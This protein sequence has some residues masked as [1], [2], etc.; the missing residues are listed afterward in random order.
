MSD[1]PD[2]AAGGMPR[3]APA[4]L[5][6]AATEITNTSAVTNGALIALPGLADERARHARRVRLLLI[7]LRLIG[8][9]VLL[10]LAFMSA[11][12]LRYVLEFGR[13]VV[14]PESFRPLS[15]FTVYILAFTAMTLLSFQT[16][17]LYSL[18]R[19]ASWFDQ[20]RIIAGATLVGVAALTL[21]ALFFS[22]EV[23]SRLLFIYL[24][25]VTLGIFSVE[26]FA[27]K[28]L[29]VWLWRHGINIRRTIVVGSGMAGQRIMK[30]IVEHPELGYQMAG[31]VTDSADSPGSE[32]WRVPIRQKGALKRLGSLKDV[33]RIIEQ[34]NLNEVIV[35][36]PA[37]HHTQI[38][39]IID[40]CREYGVD[41][42][43]VP[44]LF[45]MRFNE[46]RID[47]LNDVPLIGVKDVALRGFNLFI[48]RVLDIVLAVV[49]L[50]LAGIPMLIIS[51]LIKATS[52]GPVLFRQERVGRGGELFVCYKFRTMY[53]DAEQ[54]KEELRA[55]NE[56]QGPM[57]KMRNDP[58][59]TSV[60]KV[61]RRTSLDE[62]PNLF[63]I[64]KGEMSWV[65]PRP[66]TPDEAAQ[67]NDWHRKRLDVTPGL[68]GLWQ[69]SGRSDLT[70]DEM[71]KL[72][73]FYAENWSL[74]LDTKI[75]LKTVPAVLKR[76]GAY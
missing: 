73:L 39:G 70:F 48:K 8:D 16:R 25:V 37:T 35:A 76:E 40:S 62:L 7:T 64:L 14:A 12:A 28:A 71:V 59:R 67:Y 15:A 4:V 6:S 17:G 38:L 72:D 49:V 20:M 50:V 54:R 55:H 74:A 19:G 13:D 31:Y 44:D 51:L 36:L 58:R 1:H 11:Y 22:G 29:R 42:K 47:A 63:N 26:R 68:T 9:A 56:A 46:V 21:G 27:Y 69:V 66:P 18:P 65:G 52:P 57:F 24:W 10:V 43:L 33:R 34:Q 60:G 30:D 41:F 5:E 53:K 23:P 45:E 61:L 3:L 75:I 32:E 2:G